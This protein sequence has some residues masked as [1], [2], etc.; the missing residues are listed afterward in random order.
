MGATGGR[1]RVGCIVARVILKVDALNTTDIFASA[2]RV[3]MLE[4][5]SNLLELSWSYRPGSGGMWD[6]R[7]SF[8]VE[9]NS[10]AWKQLGRGRYG[11]AWIYREPDSGRDMTTFDANEG[12]R[13]LWFG[14]LENVSRD[15]EAE[16]VSCTLRGAG[17]ILASTVIDMIDTPG[18]QGGTD[19]AE[20]LATNAVGQVAAQ[21]PFPSSFIAAVGACARK[22]YIDE[23]SISCSEV[24]EKLATQIGGSGVIAW[25][26]RP[27]G[28]ADD[29]GEIYFQPW[30][31]SL[32]ERSAGFLVPSWP[33]R[34]SSLLSLDVGRDTR[35]L[36]NQIEV[37]LE[38]DEFRFFAARA[39]SESSIKRFGRRRLRIVDRN[40]Q[41]T[42][43]AK[44]VAAGKLE[45]LG[46]PRLSLSAKFEDRL[47]PGDQAGAS[48]GAE[49][50]LVQTAF[51]Q[52]ARPVNLMLEDLTPPAVVGVSPYVAALREEAAL[53]NLLAVDT[54][55]ADLVDG[56]W[57]PNPHE[58]SSFATNEGQL[59]VITGRFTGAN[60]S[61]NM[62]LWEIDRKLCL[63]LAHISGDNYQVALIQRQSGGWTTIGAGGVNV[64]FTLGAAGTNLDELQAF[65]ILIWD[66]AGT[67]I[68][69]V[70]VYRI[71][72]NGTRTTI[73]DWT[74]GVTPA[75]YSTLGTQDW[76]LVNGALG[77]GGTAVTNKPWSRDFDLVSFDVYTGA[78]QVSS[79]NFGAFDDATELLDAIGTKGPVFEAAATRILSTQLGFVS[80]G[81][82]PSG[83]DECA[84]R[85]AYKSE[86][87]PHTV[88]RS[89]SAFI[90]TQGAS[91]FTEDATYTVFTN[92]W[93]LGGGAEKRYL[94]SGVE[95]LPERVICTYQGANDPILVDLQGDAPATSVLGTIEALKRSVEEVQR[96]ADE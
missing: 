64:P 88:E 57:H 65:G 8:R 45:E 5:S 43:Q 38:R 79:P 36:A 60:P 55:S 59:H 58:T 77:T 13:L 85:W 27:A 4:C 49:S 66:N 78:A 35:K 96:T 56:R 10:K 87:S 24:L 81:T 29:L 84:V 71:D 83:T 67:G 42:G 41:T 30:A 92:D 17:Q 51:A 75:N 94:G 61:A 25:G 72:S 48:D 69:S 70:R 73:G 23:E 19:T 44:T 33:I 1:V 53:G 20:Q 74:A 93:L 6:G 90:A 3:A 11:A 2:N 76:I 34:A 28:G 63:V 16:V 39:T 95:I 7:A 50:G 31:S 26:V 18:G 47:E 21:G 32:W 89:V 86:G 40:V 14:T 62:S 80:S 54:S 37:Y 91:S 52:G 15:P 22:V 68:N 9:R 46:S 12:N 82:G